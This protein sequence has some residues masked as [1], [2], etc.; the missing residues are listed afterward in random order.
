LDFVV[1]RSWIIIFERKTKRSFFLRET[2]F[3]GA[4]ERI[5]FPRG[6]VFRTRVW[7][8]GILAHFI[9][10]LE[11]SFIM[12]ILSRKDGVPWL[13]IEGALRSIVATLL[14]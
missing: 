11:L 10:E 8:V 12:F 3:E 2:A 13:S 1:T 4:L 14:G 5:R 6:I 7:L 9:R